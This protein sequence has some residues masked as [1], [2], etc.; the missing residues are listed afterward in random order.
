MSHALFD[1]VKKEKGIATDAELSIALGL[2]SSSQVNRYRHGT[3]PITAALILRVYDLTGF[4]I[5]LIRDLAADT[6]TPK[7]AA[8]RLPKSQPQPW[9][10][11]KSWH[12]TAPAPKAARKS[13]Q[14]TVTEAP[15]WVSRVHRS[16]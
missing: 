4:P 8:V 2:S 7:V 6:T 11:V 16:F 5:E 9:S 1:A 12:S 15:K 14:V 13:H 3:D 10:A